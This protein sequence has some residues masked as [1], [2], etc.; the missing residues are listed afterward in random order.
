MDR[1]PI[2]N[3]SRPTLRGTSTCFR[4]SPGGWKVPTTYLPYPLFIL[5]PTYQRTQWVDWGARVASTFLFASCGKDFTGLQRYIGL[6][7]SLAPSSQALL[8]CLI[9]N[10][11]QA[12]A[13]LLCVIGWFAP[14]SQ[15]FYLCAS[16]VCRGFRAGFG[17]RLWSG[18]WFAYLP[19][20]LVC[21]LSDAFVTRFSYL[22]QT[23]GHT[24]IHSWT[25]LLKAP[26]RYALVVCLHF[27][28]P[29]HE[30]MKKFYRQIRNILAVV[31]YRYRDLEERERKEKDIDL[32]SLVEYYPKE[33]R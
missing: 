30:Q 25:Y 16:T 24:L 14:S 33:R 7:G 6:I 27:I 10:L 23:K 21:W 19:T 8:L 15:T 31:G 28:P 29:N 5:V 20:I 3:N 17:T 4:G 9:G 18:F 11:P 12:E 1:S 22:W 32:T 13:S 2:E 26:L